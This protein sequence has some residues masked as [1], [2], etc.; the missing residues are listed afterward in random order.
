MN[1]FSSPVKLWLVYVIAEGSLHHSWLITCLPSTNFQVVHQL[2]GDDN[3]KHPQSWLRKCDWLFRIH[4]ASSKRDPQELLSQPDAPWPQTS[5]IQMW[6][7]SL[8]ITREAHL[9]LRDICTAAQTSITTS[10]HSSVKRVG[11][12]TSRASADCA[13]NTWKCPTSLRL[14][15]KKNK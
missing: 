8:D 5:S 3:C 1:S 14:P 4:E 2:A 11:A 7:N 6:R 13:A 10:Q 15:H 12:I 9:G